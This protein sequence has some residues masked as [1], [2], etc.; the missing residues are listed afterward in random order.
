MTVMVSDDDFLDR[1]G[2][3]C[4]RRSGLGLCPGQPTDGHRTGRR[5][6]AVAPGQSRTRSANIVHGQ[7]P[8]SDKDNGLIIRAERGV[9]IA[10]RMGRGGDA[11]RSRCH[12]KPRAVNTRPSERTGPLR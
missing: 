9:W 3:I 8:P 7:G 5:Q 6:E 11:V 10:D 12:P 2:V 4:H 1:S